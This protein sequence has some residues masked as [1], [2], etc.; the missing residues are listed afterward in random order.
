MSVDRNFLGLRNLVGR[1]GKSDGEALYAARPGTIRPGHL[2]PGSLAHFAESQNRRKTRDLIKILLGHGA[3]S[4]R[5]SQPR[6][7]IAI[8]VYMPNGQ[9]ALRLKMAK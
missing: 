6:T 4:A 2:R 7:H 3:R 9:R 8:N 1:R 5:L